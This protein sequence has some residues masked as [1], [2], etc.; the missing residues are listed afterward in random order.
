MNLFSS[1]EK[2]EHVLLNDISSGS[3][4]GAL[5]LKEKKYAPLVL[6]TVRKS[7]PLR[8]DLDNYRTEKDILKI[9][10]EVCQDVLKNTLRKP[11]KVYCVMGTPWSY[12]ELKTIRHESK[13][14]FKFTEKFAKKLVDAELDAF[15]AKWQ[16]LKQIIDNRVTRVTLNGYGLNKPHGEHARIVEIDVFLSLAKEEFVGKIEEIIHRTFKTETR[17]VSQMFSDFVVVRDVFDVQN[18]FTIINFGEEVTEVSLMK[19]DSLTGTAFFPFGKSKIIRLI[20]AELSKD[21][22][23]A[24]SLFHVYQDNFLEDSLQNGLVGAVQNAGKAWTENLK[25]VLAPLSFN[26]QLPN[27][28]F[29]I[30]DHKVEKWL[31]VYL[32]KSFFPEFTISHDNFNVIMGD[33]RVL[34]DYVDFA[35]GVESDHRLIMKVIFI[36]H[37]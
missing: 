12:G 21:M 36:N 20:G 30:T 34:H 27:N 37:L 1:S 28:I 23:E 24:K 17:F 10:D 26:S 18:D 7:V 35:H 13:K 15:R 25:E 3:V 2:G 8:T 29:L 11:E 32:N 16:N 5:V 19:S 4:A 31:E 33:S 14:E 9:L 22:H 6:H